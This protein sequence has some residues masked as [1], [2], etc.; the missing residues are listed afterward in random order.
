MRKLR[1]SIRHLLEIVTFV[2]VV[3]GAFLEDFSL[4]AIPFILI[5]CAIVLLN[6]FILE[7]Y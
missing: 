5:G 6:V 2:L 7:R 1:P 3:F 4:S